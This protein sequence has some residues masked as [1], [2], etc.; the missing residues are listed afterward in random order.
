MFLSN[1]FP[2]AFGLD[3]GDLSLKLV[4]LSHH[5][6]LRGSISYSVEMVRSVSLPPGLILNGE[7]QQPEAVR[8]KILLLIGKEGSQ[9][10]L[11]TP[12]VVANLPEPKTFLKLITVDTPASD[13]LYDDVAY[14]ARKHVPF[15]IEDTYLDW[16]VISSNDQNK[17][18]GTQLLIGA[19]P[20]VIADSYT[21]L[22]EAAGLN[23]IALE[24]ESVAIA[25]TMMTAGKDYTGMARAILD[26]GATRSS[27]LI[28]DH[29]SIQFST[30]LNFS[31]ELVTT[32]I[33]QALKVDY[34]AA[35]KLK[36]ENGMAYDEKNPKYLTAVSALVDAL[37]TDI[38]HALNFYREHFNDPNPVTHIT[39]CGGSSLLK[40]MPTVLT[41]K[42]KIETNPGN[43]WKN[44]L[45]RPP[46]EAEKVSGINFAAAL[47]LALRAASNPLHETD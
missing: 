7:I 32:A 33:V 18:G 5:H 4:R 10:P 47:G 9:K 1:P 23:P 13:L 34:A 24:I 12:W 19:V 26:L 27:L 15:E 22:L 41:Q 30:S 28:F 40:N 29:D 43:V 39:L 17:P 44:I 31:G 37:V 14:H 21:Y 25:R 38:K 45:N 16:Q 6:A 42:L 8:K 46:T 2:G 20:K 3:I 35:E 36:F 11:G